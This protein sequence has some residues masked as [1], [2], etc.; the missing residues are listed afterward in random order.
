M[1]KTHKAGDATSQ[2]RARWIRP[3]VR[4]MSAGSAEDGATA[5]TDS[6]IKPS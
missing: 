6:G 5:T 2:E 4:R 3:A 1:T